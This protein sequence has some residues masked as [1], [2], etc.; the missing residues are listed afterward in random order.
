MIPS[1]RWLCEHHDITRVDVEEYCER[2][3]CS[4]R[5]AREWLV[6]PLT[7]TLQMFDED[8][9]EWIDVPTVSVSLGKRYE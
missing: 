8:T 1:L 6:P 2:H 5:E 3:G 4:F 9:Q 7:P